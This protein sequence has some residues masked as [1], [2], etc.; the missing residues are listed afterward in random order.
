MLL[1]LSVVEQRYHAVMV[2]PAPQQPKR[3]TQTSSLRR[4][5]RSAEMGHNARRADAFR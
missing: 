3:T 5:T 2:E 1:E 4:S